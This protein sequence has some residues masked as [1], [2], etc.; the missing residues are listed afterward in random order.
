[1]SLK[2][3]RRTLMMKRPVYLTRYYARGWQSRLPITW[4]SASPG[5]IAGCANWGNGE[6]ALL[7]HLT[8]CLLLE[9][10]TVHRRRLDLLAPVPAH[11][12]HF[13]PQRPSPRVA[14]RLLRL[15]HHR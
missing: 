4:K 12:T 6:P 14:L 11:P 5:V 15:A 7:D 8:E 3:E 2:V 13:A 10:K 9:I 1:M